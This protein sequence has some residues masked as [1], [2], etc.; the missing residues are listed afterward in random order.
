MVRD[1]V[2]FRG[3][4]AD[5]ARSSQVA[6]SKSGLRPTPP[7]ASAYIVA[8]TAWVKDERNEGKRAL[9]DELLRELLAVRNI[10]P[11]RR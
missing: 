7:D 3:A 6:S 11:R 4:D 2:S 5:A 10:T 1:G 8:F 9:K